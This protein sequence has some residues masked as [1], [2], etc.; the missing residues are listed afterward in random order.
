MKVTGPSKE[1][2]RRLFVGVEKYAKKTKQDV[3]W[4]VVKLMARPSR[5]LAAVNVKR[6]AEL[7]GQVKESKTFVVPGKVLGDGELTVALKV[8]AMGF[9]ADAKKKIASAKGNAMSLSELMAKKPKASEI[10]VVV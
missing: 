2:T 1:S 6:L 7:A 4:K 5:K 3:W 9:S 8:A 10:M